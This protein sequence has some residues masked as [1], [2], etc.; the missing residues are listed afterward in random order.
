M[1]KLVTIYLENTYCRAE[2]SQKNDVSEHLGGY[3]KDGWSIVRITPIGSGIG[4]GVRDRDPFI[5]GWL[6]VLMER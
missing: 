1:Q 2:T 6:A 4:S 5:A 3:L